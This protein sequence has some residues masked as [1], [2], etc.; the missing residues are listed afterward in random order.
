MELENPFGRD[1]HDINLELVQQRMDQRLQLLLKPKAQRSPTLAGNSRHALKGNLRRR[2]SLTEAWASATESQTAG[3][4]ACSYAEGMNCKSTGEAAAT[5]P[6]TSPLA[7]T[8][9]KPSSQA[10]TTDEQLDTLAS[11]MKDLC[12]QLS[13]MSVDRLP[14]TPSTS[15]LQSPRDA[16]RT[17]VPSKQQNLDRHSEAQEFVV[18]ASSC[19]SLSPRYPRNVSTCL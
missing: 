17:C 11:T 3:E 15:P 1:D 12:D 2:C 6:P 7:K 18:G 4:E 13:H 8:G 16:P 14:C 10:S 19:L 9:S 5:T